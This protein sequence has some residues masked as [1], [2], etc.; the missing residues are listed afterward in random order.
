MQGRL[1]CCFGAAH[2]THV[3]DTRLLL[4]CRTGSVAEGLLT[5]EWVV[6]VK[7]QPLT[8][9]H[10]SKG[11]GFAGLYYV[12]MNCCADY[13]TQGMSSS[14]AGAAASPPHRGLHSSASA[15]CAVLGWSN[16]AA[17]FLQGTA[18][19]YPAVCGGGGAVAAADLAPG[20]WL[21]LLTV[22]GVV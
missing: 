11:Q 10:L 8:D 21:Q 22:L 1:R 20:S 14:A 6:G 2:C 7:A 17:C 5:R 3:L 15:L 18:L 13:V 12:R 9:Q 16:L 19:W 4:G